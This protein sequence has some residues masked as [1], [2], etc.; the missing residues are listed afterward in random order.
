MRAAHSNTMAWCARSFPQEKLNLVP[1]DFHPRLR[2]TLRMSG[3]LQTC[4]PLC[5][6]RNVA[7]VTSWPLRRFHFRQRN[8][9]FSQTRA[10]PIPTLTPPNR[11]AQTSVCVL[12]SFGFYYSIS[13][14]KPHRLKPVLLVPSL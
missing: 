12:L 11:V 10:I 9:A 6:C 4:A 13:K 2:F 1:L 5:S 8:D 3:T 7:V 14:S